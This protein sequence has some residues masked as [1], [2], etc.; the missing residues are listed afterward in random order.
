MQQHISVVLTLLCPSIF[1]R[2]RI[3]CPEIPGKAPDKWAYENNVPPDFIKPGKPV[4]K[5]FIEMFNGRLRHECLNQRYFVTLHEK[6]PMK[7]G[8]W[9]IILFGS[10]VL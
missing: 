8:G 3:S 7:I 5:A 4:Q 10:T 6:K 9:S 1:I 2:F